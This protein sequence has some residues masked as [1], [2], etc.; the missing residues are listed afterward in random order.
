M[1]ARKAKEPK[2]ICSK[3]K[4]VP[5]FTMPTEVIK[6]QCVNFLSN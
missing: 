5:Q 2:V 3:F 4:D 1:F 6:L